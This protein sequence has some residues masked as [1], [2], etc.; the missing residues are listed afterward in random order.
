MGWNSNR[1]YYGYRRYN[2]AAARLNSLVCGLLFI[3]FA[4]VYIAVFQNDLLGAMHY[5]MGNGYN[6]FHIVP[7]TII[8]ILILMLMEW[9]LNLLMRL[10]GKVRA[11][12]FLPSYLGLVTLT[13][14]GRNVYMGNFS[15]KWWW[16]MPVF[17]VVYV[18]AVVLIRKNFGKTKR[19]TNTVTMVIWSIFLMLAMSVGTAC[20]GNTDRYFHNE[21]RMERLM[22][23]K[24]YGE[25]LKVAGKSLRTTRTMT[26]LRMMAMVKE[27][28]T[29]E[30]LFEFP[31]YYK[32]KGMFF[33]ND[34]SKT[35]RYTNDSVYAML[36][37]KP[38]YGESTMD[39]LKRLSYGNDSCGYARMYYM[40][41]LMLKK[42]LEG[43]SHVLETFKNE[44]DTLQRYFKEAAIVY[45]EIN[46]EWS[47]EIDDTDSI[48]HKMRERYIYRQKDEYKSG[49]EERNKMR[50]EFGDTFW[51][52]YDYQE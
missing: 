42:D 24:R 2:K 33:D 14:F 35:L 49:N 27:G 5:S 22:A 23:G 52:Y 28:R 51:W 10:R 40:A 3:I 46:P 48:Y 12:A 9:G 25:V 31:Q 38:E 19:Q 1:N 36:G 15:N 11:L 47:L 26:A 7:A 41:G 50:L 6:E 20:L 45:K 30:M 29:G 37:G 4:T 34:S 16:I 18:I 39:Y 17:T 32:E 8:I 43:L 44:G 13:G 21:L